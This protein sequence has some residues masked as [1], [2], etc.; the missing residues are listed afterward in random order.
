[1]KLD[2]DIKRIVS[3]ENIVTELETIN[4][5]LVNESDRCKFYTLENETIGKYGLTRNSLIERV[6]ALFLFAQPKQELK[7]A[8]RIHYESEKDLEA[9][10]NKTNYYSEIQMSEAYDK[11][12]YDQTNQSGHFNI[13]NY[14]PEFTKESD[15]ISVND[16]MPEENEHQCS[17]DVL[18][19]YSLGLISIGFTHKG[20]WQNETGERNIEDVRN[21]KPLP[22]PPKNK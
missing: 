12:A 19:Y 6:L 16:R 15:W 4:K 14:K 8:N 20:F 22:K 17:E 1:M 10:E 9:K 11:G 21:W 7:T 3:N 18:T 5:I 2:S 13:H